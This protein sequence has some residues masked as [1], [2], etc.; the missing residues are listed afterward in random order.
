MT[1]SNQI[2]YVKEERKYK[3]KNIYQAFLHQLA[4]WD[5][6]RTARWLSLIKNP[7]E[8]LLKTQQLL[9]VA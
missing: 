5:D 4:R 8:M 9:S 7:K 2:N 1:L 6:F 3:I